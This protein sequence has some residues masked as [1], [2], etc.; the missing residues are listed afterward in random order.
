MD[1]D[2]KLE[3]NQPLVYIA[4]YSLQNTFT[5]ITSFAFQGCMI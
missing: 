4:F 1:V 3:I 2:C 5:Y